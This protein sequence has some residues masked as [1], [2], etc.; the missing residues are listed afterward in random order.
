MGVYLLTQYAVF[1]I[2]YL[3]QQFVC[4]ILLFFS[5]ERSVNIIPGI[6]HSWSNNLCTLRIILFPAPIGNVLHNNTANGGKAGYLKRAADD[7]LLSC[8]AQAMRLIYFT[9]SIFSNVQA[10]CISALSILVTLL[11]AHGHHSLPE[12]Y[13]TIYLYSELNKTQNYVINN[14]YVQ[15]IGC[16]KKNVKTFGGILTSIIQTII[17]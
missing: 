7:R 16:D 13:L 17:I 15:L 1:A 9:T 14:Q 3:Y 2:R 5:N 6:N 12:I 10:K 11:A 4:N 8:S